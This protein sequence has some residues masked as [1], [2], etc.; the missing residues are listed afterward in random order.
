MKR[1]I[2]LLLVLLLASCHPRKEAVKPVI[3]EV[4][5]IPVEKKI[6]IALGG[7]GARGFSQIGVLRV[8]E[9]EKIPVS[10]VAGTSVGS[11]IGALYCDTGKI[12]D[13]EFHA[14][15]I[16]QDD[17]FDYS[18]FSILSGGV[19]KGEKLEDFLRRN[20]RHTVLE[21]LDIPLTVV[22]T[23]LRTGESVGFRSGSVPVAVHASCAIPGIF[24]PV[25]ISDRVFVDG[26]VSDPV[27]VDFVKKMGADIVIAVAIPPEIPTDP[28]NRTTEIFRHSA[29]IMFSEIANCKIGEADVVIRPKCG[30]VRFND[31]TKRRELLLA[32][33]DA[34]REMLPKLRELM[35]G[36]AE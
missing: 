32:G 27:P 33:E 34:A 13:L 8:L 31:F 28:P 7:G 36:G 2:M 17:I 15:T 29:A 26:G 20:L 5:P 23:D 14:V 30:I 10:F 19:V 12:V 24:Q 16:G 3:P 6:G 22:A 25:Q 4:P 1:S 21:D 35:E 18:L 11:L 9:Q